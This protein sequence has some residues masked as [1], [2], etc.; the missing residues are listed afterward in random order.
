MQTQLSLA[1]GDWS[2]EHT[3]QIMAACRA[4]AAWW[5]AQLEQ[6]NSPAKYQDGT[7]GPAGIIAALGNNKVAVPATSQLAG[8]EAELGKSFFELVR[9]RWRVHVTSICI[10]TEYAPDEILAV[11]ARNNGINTNLFPWKTLLWFRTTPG[12]VQVLVGTSHG[13]Q[14]ALPRPD[15]NS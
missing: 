1:P 2:Q 7:P 4:G 5:R 15:A 11:A 6:P 3:E 13:Q 8:F 12:Q 9:A 10:G 14:T